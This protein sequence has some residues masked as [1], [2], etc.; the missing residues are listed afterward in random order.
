MYNLSDV[1]SGRFANIPSAIPSESP[2]WRGRKLKYLTNGKM[3]NYGKTVFPY[4][5]K[6]FPEVWAG[7]GSAA[8]TPADLVNTNQGKIGWYIDGMDGFIVKANLT[9]ETSKYAISMKDSNVEN[10]LW[11]LKPSHPFVGSGQ[12]IKISDDLDEL[13]DPESRPTQVELETGL[14]VTLDPNRNWVVQPL[15]P[16]PVLWRGRL[17]FDCRFYAVIFRE[18]AFWKRPSEIHFRGAVL[19]LGV[20]RLAV[21][22][23]DPVKDPLSAITNISVQSRFPEY[24]PDKHMKLLYDDYGTYH[25]PGGVVRDI[26]VDLLDKT[27]LVPDLSKTAQVLILGLDVMF[28][29]DRNRIKPKLIEVNHQPYIGILDEG[30]EGICSREFV[31]GVFGMVIPRLLASSEPVNW[32]TLD[33]P[34]WD[35]FL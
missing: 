13:L 25:K 35:W 32:S 2:E 20:A 27:E 29:G 30:A 19:K 24:G 3:N 11:I 31:R 1:L 33:M 4:L 17:K 22:R 8:K 15:I 6:L 5:S 21:S 16:N 7:I 12:L 14:R 28:A 18:P 10:N 26:L 9:S 34:N 23:Y